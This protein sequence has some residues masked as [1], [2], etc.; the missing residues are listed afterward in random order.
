M[1]RKIPW[2]LIIAK[3]KG[4]ITKKENAQLNVWLAKD[5]NLQLFEELQTLWEKVQLKTAHYEPD[6][7]FYWKE[8]SVLMEKNEKNRDFL[9]PEKEKNKTF[10]IPHFTRKI[11]AACILLILAL[12]GTFFLG[13]IST[14][15]KNQTQTFVSMNGKSKV[16]LSDGTEVWLH[17]NTTLTFEEKKNKREAE[18][19]G[20]A[21]FNV[22]HNKKIPFLVKSNDI[23]VKVYGTKFNVNSYTSSDNAIVSLYEGSVALLAGDKT[24]MLKP[25]QEGNYNRIAKNLKIA[26]GD[27]EYAKSWTNDQLHFENKNIRE[28]CKYLS[29]WYSAEI[30]IDN[31][32]PNDQSYTFTLQNEPLEEVVRIMARI[33]SFDYQFLENNRLV[34]Q[35]Q[36]IKSKNNKPMQK[37]P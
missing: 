18:L 19:N 14:T 2:N 5:Q 7:E 37:T 4:D 21:F 3:L 6:T 29:K 25:G 33:N 34:I 15:K 28:I 9:P 16:V 36:T 24:I 8:L 22:T 11:A 20:E 1:K 26:Y 13:Q 31:R 17:S 12:S 32:I 30:I 10:S 27:I 23:I 35:P